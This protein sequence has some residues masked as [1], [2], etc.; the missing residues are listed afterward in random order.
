MKYT[1]HLKFNAKTNEGHLY[2][3]INDITIN[4][5]RTYRLENIK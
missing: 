4:T 5:K 3:H 1:R 2:D